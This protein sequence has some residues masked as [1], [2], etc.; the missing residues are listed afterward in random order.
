MSPFEKQ[1]ERFVLQ[2]G[3]CQFAVDPIP[4]YATKRPVSFSIDWDA[5]PEGSEQ[6]IDWLGYAGIGKE[7]NNFESYDCLLI[8]P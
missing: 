1:R 6:R 3:N 4:H 7:K 8:P 5:S 2:T